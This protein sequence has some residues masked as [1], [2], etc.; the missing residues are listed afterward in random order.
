MASSG[1]PQQIKSCLAVNFVAFCGSAGGAFEAGKNVL[2]LRKHHG[3]AGRIGV[4][5]APQIGLEAVFITGRV[6]DLLTFLVEEPSC[7]GA[8]ARCKCG[9]RRL[10]T[11]GPTLGDRINSATRE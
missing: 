11:G 1:L 4:D 7:D 5:H 8:V 6:I 3:L 2:F 9:S 10:R